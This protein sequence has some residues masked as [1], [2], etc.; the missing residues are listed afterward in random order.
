MGKES[1]GGLSGTRDLWSSPMK[2]FA[3][4]AP[5]LPVPILL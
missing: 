2:K 3:D 1:G 5:V 4:C